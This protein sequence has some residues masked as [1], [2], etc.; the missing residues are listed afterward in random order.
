[1][2]NQTSGSL[3]AAGNVTLTVSPGDL[4]GTIQVSGTY[5]SNTY[6]IEVT[7]DS[8]SFGAWPCFQGLTPT[9]GTISP[10]DNSTVVY[11][12][13]LGNFTAMRLR[14]TDTLGTGTLNVN[15]ASSAAQFPF[16]IVVQTA[17]AVNSI[18]VSTAATGTTTANAGALPSGSKIYPT[19]A[20]DDTKGVIINSG[21]QITGY[22]FTVGNGVSNKILKVYPPSGGS[23]NGAAA[24]AAYS[25]ASGKSVRMECLSATANTWF[26]MG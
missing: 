17:P 9:T 14:R 25:S 15:L 1:M 7:E 10:A 16:A 3:N 8:S 21:D 19:T 5:G 6:V 26:A 4:T 20:A 2:P 13:P 23:I 22:V 18:G 11:K 24:D 12:V